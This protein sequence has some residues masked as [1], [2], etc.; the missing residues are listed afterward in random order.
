[1]PRV[2]ALLDTQQISDVLEIQGEDSKHLEW[3]RATRS[4]PLTQFQ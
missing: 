1:M 2:A 3:L 4:V